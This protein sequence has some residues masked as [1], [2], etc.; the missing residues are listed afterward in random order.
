MRNFFSGV[1][2]HAQASRLS[3]HRAAGLHR[4]VGLRSQRGVC[5]HAIPGRFSNSSLPPLFVSGRF[6]I[7]SYTGGSHVR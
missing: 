4:F 6:A 7:L 3:A 2:L 1:G 5:R